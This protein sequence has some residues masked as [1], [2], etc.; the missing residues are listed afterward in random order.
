MKACLPG[1]ET[2]KAQAIPVKMSEIT[3]GT[4]ARV[5]VLSNRDPC[6]LRIVALLYTLDNKP[7]PMLCV[8]IVIG[9]IMSI[10]LKGSR[11]KFIAQYLASLAEQTLE[12]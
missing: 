5:F 4:I 9:K 2:L 12:L 6:Y 11:R 7:I 8:F 1:S 10:I 3:C